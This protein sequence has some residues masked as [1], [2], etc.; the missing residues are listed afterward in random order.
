MLPGSVYA[1]AL[2]CSTFMLAAVGSLLGKRV[3]IVGACYGRDGQLPLKIGN[4]RPESS[5]SSLGKPQPDL[6]L[7]FAFY[8]GAALLILCE[9][10]VLPTPLM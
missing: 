3:G 6:D 1:G 7:P 4:S 2:G 9:T 5:G 8:V 10:G